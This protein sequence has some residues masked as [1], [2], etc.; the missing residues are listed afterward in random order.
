MKQTLAELLKSLHDPSVRDLAWALWSPPLITGH[1]D[2]PLLDLPG[3]E[4]R[5]LIDWL[6]QLDQ[7]P[8]RLHARLPAS[9]QRRLGL[10][11]ESLWQFLLEKAPL[12]TEPTT[13]LAHNLAVYQPEAIGKGRVT[14]GAFDFLLQKE[15]ICQHLEV[16]VKFYLGVPGREAFAGDWN[17]WPGPDSN[18]RAEVKFHRMASH[19][20]KLAHTPEGLNTLESLCGHA[21]EVEPAAVI[22]GRFFY[23]AMQQMTSPQYSHPRHLRG[24]WWYPQDFLQHAADSL[25]VFLPKSRWLSPVQLP[26]NQGMNK[27]ALW[28]MLTKEGKTRFPVMIAELESSDGGLYERSRHCV[29]PAHWPATDTPSF[30]T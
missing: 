16:T 15:H 22:R 18:D 28:D 23:P 26:K 3:L 20:L 6:H 5:A 29:V 30:N 25:F 4:N 8:A 10:Y 17:A 2:I 9:P 1:P 13:L 24:Q 19:Q 7:Q 11:F 21:I 12:F 14:V 27:S